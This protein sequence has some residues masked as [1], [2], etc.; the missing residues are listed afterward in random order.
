MNPSYPAI[1]VI[2]SG[3]SGVGKTT[4]C[5][6]L[7]A[8]SSNIH[9]SVSCTTRAPRPGEQVGIHY[10]YLSPEEF[11]RRK[12]AG[13]FLEYAQVHCHSYGTLRSEVTPHL[14][15][16]CDVILDIDVQGARQIRKNL[17]GQELALRFISVF[18]LPPSFAILERRLRGRKTEDEA[19][20]SRRLEHARQE[21]QHWREYDY[22][23]INQEEEEEQAARQLWA[24]MQAARLRTCIQGKEFW[25]E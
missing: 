20:I 14:D 4:V 22:V 1:A 19:E 23:L 3:P 10:H 5:R 21:L 7:V 12:E 15:T 6:Q 17:E 8:L 11:N 13:E 24:I 2:F 16:G 18:L 9:F 25:H